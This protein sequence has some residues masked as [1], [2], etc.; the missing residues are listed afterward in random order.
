[1]QQERAIHDAT[2]QAVSVNATSGHSAMALAA[3]TE[4]DG[5]DDILF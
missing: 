1:M 2:V 3:K 5:L 4:A